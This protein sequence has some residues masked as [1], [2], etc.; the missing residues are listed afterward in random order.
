MKPLVGRSG[1]R[2]SC[3]GYKSR[4]FC[5]CKFLPMGVDIVL[6]VV[7]Y[8]DGNCLNMGRRRHAG[9]QGE[10]LRFTNATWA[11]VKIPGHKHSFL[12]MLNSFANFGRCWQLVIM[13]QNSWSHG[14][15]ILLLYGRRSCYLC[16]VI[17]AEL[18]GV[19]RIIAMSRHA[20]RQALAREFGATDIISERGDEAVEKVFD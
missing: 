13:L 19:E 3:D 17:A 1:S 16:G 4:W 10:Y 12:Y 2:L 9:Y 11:L 8:F 5:H 7:C 18:L 14:W 6:L 15:A 20:D